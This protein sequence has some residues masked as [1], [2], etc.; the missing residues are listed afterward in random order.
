MWGG[1]TVNCEYQKGVHVLELATKRWSKAK[2]T[3]Q[4]P[5]FDNGF[6]KYT[7]QM[8]S[9]VWQDKLLVSP[10]HPLVSHCESQSLSKKRPYL[11]HH[12]STAIFSSHVSHRIELRASLSMA[13]STHHFHLLQ[14]NIRRNPYPL[15]W[16]QVY[17]GGKAMWSLDLKNQAWNKHGLTFRGKSPAWAADVFL[18]EHAMAV[19]G[20][21]LYIFGGLVAGEDS[22]CLAACDLNSHTVEVLYE[23]KKKVSR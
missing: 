1:E 2:C 21:V 10:P 23:G 9:V 11:T 8:S 7:C 12:P 20:D 4:E 19:A 5:F 14:F 18:T 15:S 17:L 6:G 13:V 22:A 16:V 3:G